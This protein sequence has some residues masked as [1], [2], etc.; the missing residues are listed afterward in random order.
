ME[1]AHTGTIPV[2]TFLSLFI[3]K[4]T[5][6]QVSQSFNDGN[7]DVCWKRGVVFTAKL[8]GL[9]TPTAKVPAEDVRHLKN[10]VEEFRFMQTL[11]SLEEVESCA[12]CMARW[13]MSYSDAAATGR[14]P[15]PLMADSSRSSRSAPVE[16]L[17]EVLA[18]AGL[19]E[20]LVSRISAEVEHIG[21]E[22]V[23]ELVLAEWQA[24]PS[25]RFLTPQQARRLVITAGPM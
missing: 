17:A 5:E 14:V 23:G 4:D 18:V 6:I 13:I 22:H 12:P 9:W 21:V 16:L 2:A 3:G 7:L 1:F 8:D 11:T 15:L 25:W 24:L 19:P 10:R 20:A